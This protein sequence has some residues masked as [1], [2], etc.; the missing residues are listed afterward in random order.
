L[1]PALADGEHL[2]AAQRVI[3]SDFVITT[4]VHSTTSL[5]MQAAVGTIR[6]LADQKYDILNN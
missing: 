1:G 5:S 3:I 2:E 4:I 6:T